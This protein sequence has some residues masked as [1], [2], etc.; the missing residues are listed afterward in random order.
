M[1]GH[2]IS[3]PPSHGGCLGIQEENIPDMFRILLKTLGPQVELKTSTEL[4]A[5]LVY[6]TEALV[7][8]LTSEHDD[9][10]NDL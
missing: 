8:T 1:T 9:V 6:I 7:L 4:P 2:V 3:C 5:A 10:L